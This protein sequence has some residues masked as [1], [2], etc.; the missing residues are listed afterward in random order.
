V[1]PEPEVEPSS[2]RGE[3][4]P[5][6]GTAAGTVGTLPS[7]MSV[8]SLS[9]RQSAPHSLGLH[10]AFGG[11]ATGTSGSS[12]LRPARQTFGGSWVGAV[13]ANQDDRDK[14][15]LSTTASTSGLE[16]TARASIEAGHRHSAKNSIRSGIST[17]STADMHRGS[18]RSMPSSKGSRV[19]SA[20]PQQPEGVM[21]NVRQNLHA[22]RRRVVPVCRA[23]TKNKVFQLVMLVAL[24]SALFLPDFWILFDRPDNSDLDV[25]LT[26]VLVLFIGELTVQ[27]IGLSRTYWGSF[28]FWMDLLG[29]ASLLL[30]LSYLPIPLTR[31]DGHDVSGN[32]V[33]MR[34]ARVAKLGARAGRFTKLVKL[35]RFLPGI[36]EKGTTVGTAKLISVR[37]TTILSTRVSCLIIV[38]VMIMPLFSIWTFPEQDWS[39]S[40][41]LEILEGLSVIEDLQFEEQLDQFIKFYADKGYYPYRVEG[42]LGADLSNSTVALLPWTSSRGPPKRRLNIVRL[43]TARLACDFSFKQPTQITSLMN[44]VLMVFIMLLMVC[45]SIM[46]S[47]SVSA[48]VFLP[49]EKLLLQVRLM[50]SKIFQSVASLAVEV[51]EE[52]MSDEDSSQLNDGDPSQ[53]FGCEAR[54][55]EKVMSKLAV[56]SD[57][58]GN[59][60]DAETMA[61]MGEGDRAVLAGLVGAEDDASATGWASSEAEG[62]NARFLRQDVQLSAQTA[63][64]E[65]AGLSTELLN[66]WNINPLELDHARNKAAVTFF[67]GTHNHG[68][69]FDPVVLGHFLELAEA[70]YI[71]EVPYHNWYHAVD[72]T[73]CVYRLLHLCGTEHYLNNSER[74][75]LLVSATCHDVGHPGLNNIFLAEASHE[76][77]LRYN[78]KSPLE[79]MHCSRLFEFV[80]TPKCN[81]FAN[82]SVHQFQEV[83]KCCI[84]AILH[85]DNVHHFPMIKEVQMMYELHTGPVD[86]SRNSWI[87]DTS[88]PSKDVVE[89][90]R[91]ND[92]R[93]MLVRLLLHV[94]DISNC[95]KP[96]RICR[97]WAHKVLE[98]FFSQGDQERKVGIP[99]QA[100]NDREKVN[101]PMSQVGFIE[102]LVSP[103]LFAVVKVLPPLLPCAEQM[104]ENTKTWHQQWLTE[105]KPEPTAAER[106]ALAER[107]SKLEKRYQECHPP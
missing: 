83:R 104:V 27:S 98:E 45:F 61:G 59:G 12:N 25:V 93:K 70:G 23:L 92:M 46:L 88:F 94:S 95:N 69:S 100:L 81:I 13:D 66:S 3:D 107:I 34:M 19:F 86:A 84:E 72:V 47:S 8:P 63:M 74:Y 97:V 65:S 36:R 33:I 9:G 41:W 14:G 29:A 50:A 73:H 21:A 90:F 80:S 103:L 49:L 2:V 4:S 39:M 78:D 40:A 43:E 87:K 26:C 105:T 91:Q 42:K 5:H 62:E 37:L 38:M 11:G 51:E 60:V 17:G 56:F 53:V 85:T 96:F 1:V 24:L 30:D 76:L 20:A 64:I 35:L 82:L 7:I 99:V 71:K 102:F 77:A 15:S 106:Q 28:F 54:L 68:I 6:R 10:P 32:V 52:D 75:A 89:V 31:S 16:K 55:L 18:A 101:R 44:V 22:L 67:L 48:I 79:N 58:H 57:L